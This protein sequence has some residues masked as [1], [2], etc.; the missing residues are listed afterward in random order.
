[1]GSPL[2]S[3]FFGF[4]TCC[5]TTPALLNRRQASSLLL[6]SLCLS[7][8]LASP[9]ATTPTITDAHAAINIAGK[10]RGLSQRMAKAFLQIGMQVDTQRSTTVLNTTIGTFDR[11]LTA[12]QAFAPTPTIK[13]TYQELA[14]NW[15]AYKTALNTEN[16][17][18]ENGKEVLALSE[19]MLRLTNQGVTQLEAH[20]GTASGRLVNLSG[21]QRMLSQYMAKLYQAQAWGIADSTTGQAIAAARQ[22]F[23]QAHHALS[24]ETTNTNAI[25]SALSLVESQWVF[26]DK[27]LDKPAQAGSKES[28]DIA[29]TSERIYEQLDLIAGLYAQVG[30]KK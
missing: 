4:F 25:R 16:P 11:Q 14:Q 15:K 9:A 22:E 18:P 27:A 20:L 7:S 19:M 29:T 6:G 10:E 5:M 24:A 8:P 28:L 26:F 1:M 2:Q 3:R 12:L 13:N 21:R 30:A 17:K 23:A